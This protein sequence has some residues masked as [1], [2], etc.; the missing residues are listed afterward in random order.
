M[1]T[2]RDRARKFFFALCADGWERSSSH[3]LPLDYMDDQ[4]L[5]ES[6]EDY[7]SLHRWIVTEP[8]FNNI[9]ERYFS[10]I[11]ERRKR[12]LEEKISSRALSNLAAEM[13]HERL[14]CDEVLRNSQ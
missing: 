2:P 6:I 13:V 3:K 4:E 12:D 5:K 8:E 1:T 9:V 14:K 11:I 10:K 7:E